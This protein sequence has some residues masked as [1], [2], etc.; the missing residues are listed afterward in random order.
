MEVLYRDMALRFVDHFETGSGIL[1]SDNELDNIIGNARAMQTYISLFKD[2]LD[3]S[4]Q[5]NNGNIRAAIIDS[6]LD[7]RAGGNGY[8]TVNPDTIFQTALESIQRSQF[9][10]IHA[11]LRSGTFFLMNDTH[12]M[13]VDILDYLYCTI[14]RGYRGRLRFVIHNHFGLDQSDVESYAGD[15]PRKHWGVYAWYAL[16]HFNGFDR[17]RYNPFIS[18][19][20]VISDISCEGVTMIVNNI[21]W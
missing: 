12:S 11:M 17:S 13:S 21:Y 15:P 16:Q 10:D 18:R 3:A 1:F 20:T 7:Y 14:C 8:L 9:N 4:I 5:R 19:A 2:A 6:R